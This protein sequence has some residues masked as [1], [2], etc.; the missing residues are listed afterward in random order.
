ME[1]KLIEINVTLSDLQKEKI[2]KAFFNRKKI[3]LELEND[4]LTGNNTLLIP[5]KLF[6]LDSFNFGYEKGTVPNS[7]EW[8]KK[9]LYV[10]GLETFS[11]WKEYNLEVLDE[12]L[13]SEMWE[14]DFFLVASKNDKGTTYYRVDIPPTI[15]E[16]LEEARK[17]NE[18]MQIILDYSKLT[19]SI[20]Y[21]VFK[22]IG[23]L[24]ENLPSLRM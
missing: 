10:R 7:R 5:S 12:E 3:L 2:F 14:N 4:A 15:N 18:G 6:K 21:S 22:N 23:K 24:M 1:T 16:S 13:F 9:Y 8:K 17:N 20:G 19:D 11:K